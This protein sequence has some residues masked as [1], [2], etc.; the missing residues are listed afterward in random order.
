MSLDNSQPAKKRR[1]FAASTN[2]PPKPKVLIRPVSQVQLSLQQVPDGNDLFNETIGHVLRWLSKRSGPKLPKDAWEG[3]PFTLE[4]IGAQ[5]TSVV[6]MDSP[7]YWTARLDDADKY[8]PMRMWTTEIGVGQAKNGDVLFGSRLVC[9]TRGEDVPFDRTVPTF[10]RSVVRRPSVSLDHQP[11]SP[12][13]V[14]ITDESG[15]DA[16]ISLLEDK[17]R[18]CPVVVMSLAEG[19]SDFSTCLV[20]APLV[21]DRTLGAAHIFVLTGIASYQLT[22]KLGK[23]FS[24][25]REAVRLFR[26]GFDRKTSDPFSHPLTL[27]ERIRQIS[28]DSDRGAY[29]TLLS[30]QAL[31]ITAY[32]SDSEDALPSFDRVRRLNLAKERKDARSAGLSDL[33]LLEL[34]DQ[35]IKRLEVDLDKQKETYDGLLLSIQDELT[36]AEDA[37]NESLSHAHALRDRISALELCMKQLG[38]K[39]HIPSDLNELDQWGRQHLVGSVTLLPKALRGAKKS[40]FENPK[41][42]YEALLLLRDFY[43]PMRKESSPARLQAFDEE[44]KRLGL[45]NSLV[46]NPGSKNKDDYKVKF[47]GIPRD[48]DWH[49]K[50]GNS[51]DSR[52]CFRLYYFWDEES[53]CAVVGWLPSHLDNRST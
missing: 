37:K 21:Y 29:E 42:I 22:N 28:L 39:T 41:L 27:A 26:P 2:K 20:D 15:V 7:R 1:Q 36:Q 50:D 48:L 34:A 43:V 35:E 14:H 19:C 47:S 52:L 25:Y 12:G 24:V 51:R 32:A 33:K 10:V 46:G 45:E 8:V 40:D 9:T 53:Q 44:L 6:A 3:K 30:S 17:Q 18:R 23:E 49:L 11:L 13:P 5:H 38:E 31:A 16:M 4:D